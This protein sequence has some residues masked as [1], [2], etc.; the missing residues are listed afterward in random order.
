MHRNVPHVG[1]R[2]VEF[3]NYSDPRML[4]HWIHYG[5][6]M[7]RRHN[8]I[9]FNCTLCVVSD[10]RTPVACTAHCN[11]MRKGSF[12]YSSVLA[13]GC[14]PKGSACWWLSSWV[15]PTTRT[16]LCCVV[17]SS[18]GR[19]RHAPAPYYT[20]H[21]MCVGSVFTAT[22][23]ATRPMT[24]PITLKALNYS[25]AHKDGVASQWTSCWAASN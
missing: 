23:T 8:E 13:S 20:W 4:P 3:A 2:V 17:A 25:C 24:H 7:R 1:R 11:P 21:Q 9:E 12:T 10:A 22:L 5:R 15:L 6:A 14:A 18:F 16:R 19:A